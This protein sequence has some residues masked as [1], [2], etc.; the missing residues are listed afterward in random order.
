[1]SPVI[2]INA[3]PSR[4]FLFVL[5]ALVFALVPP[6]FAHAESQQATDGLNYVV[7]TTGGYYQYFDESR[8]DSY[9][10]SYICN[11]GCSQTYAAYLQVNARGYNSDLGWHKVDEVQYTC[12]YNVSTW[13]SQTP[14]ASVNSWSTGSGRPTPA[15]YITA[16]SYYY[17]GPGYSGLTAYTSATNT[18]VNRS[19]FNCWAYAGC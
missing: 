3:L 9:A 10:T 11:P 18:V 8:A 16:Q 17:P 2:V 13:C 7:G 12:G 15:M 4:R 14:A 5:A 6:L 1:M 19:S